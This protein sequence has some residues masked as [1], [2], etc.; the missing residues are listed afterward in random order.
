MRAIFVG[1]Q[2]LRSCCFASKD[3]MWSGIVDPGGDGI[4][5]RRDG[6][7]CAMWGGKKDLIQGGGQHSPGRVHA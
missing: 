5:G 3:A 4:P 2:L 1:Q 7:W 6:V